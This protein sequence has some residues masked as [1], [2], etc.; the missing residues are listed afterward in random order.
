MPRRRADDDRAPRKRRG[1]RHLA[2]PEKDPDRRKARIED[3]EEARLRRGD[4]RH[5]RKDQH[6]AEREL[7]DP[8]RREQRPVPAP[9]RGEIRERQHHQPARQ[10]RQDQHGQHVHPRVQPHHHHARRI[11]QHAGAGQQIARKAP[12]LRAARHHHHDPD[13]TGQRGG[14]GRAVEPLGQEHPPGERRDEGGGGEDHEEVRNR[15]EPER[16]DVHHHPEAVERDEGRARRPDRGQTRRR[17]APLAPPQHGPERE[18]REK[19]PPRR[20]R[21]GVGPEQPGDEARGRI[22]RRPQDE[23]KQPRP[24]EDASA[25]HGGCLLP[26]PIRGRASRRGG[27]APRGSSSW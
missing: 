15:R 4:P 17:A 21:E 2:Q 19:P 6:R 14:K 12:R 5:R 10:H 24:G 1:R 13:Q 9:D 23:D 27:P 16:E 25:R 3:P 20:G 18:R 8:Q 7:K 26:G 11:G 22:D